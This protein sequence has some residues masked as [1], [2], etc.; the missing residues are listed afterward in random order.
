[1]TIP[2]FAAEH[3]RLRQQHVARGAPAAID[4]YL[5]RAGPSANPPAAVTAV[6]RRDSQTDKTDGWT[7]ARPFTWTLFRIL[8]GQPQ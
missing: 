2:A 7:D 5:L 3:R 6:H 8:S 1:M 4:R